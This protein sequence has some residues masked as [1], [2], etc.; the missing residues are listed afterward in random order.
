[1]PR[2]SVIYRFAFYFE[3]V[4]LLTLVALLA[5]HS[6]AL[7]TCDSTR[8]CIY[9]IFCNWKSGKY[10]HRVRQ[11]ASMMLPAYLPTVKFGVRLKVYATKLLIP[12][13]FLLNDHLGI[14][15]Y[16]SPASWH[17][18]NPTNTSLPPWFSICLDK[19]IP[20]RPLSPPL[21]SGRS[22]SNQTPSS[23]KLKSIFSA[24]SVNRSPSQVK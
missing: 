13:H 11:M 9:R 21:N 8:Q 16:R 24:D 2:N 20:W 23:R 15:T 7:A 14:Y 4:K 1:M 17:I 19:L 12:W 22:A 18:H 6:E 10:N 3:R 5:Q